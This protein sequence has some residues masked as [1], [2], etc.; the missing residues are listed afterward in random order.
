ME[1]KNGDPTGFE[2]AAKLNF[3]DDY[4]KVHIEAK[5]ENGAFIDLTD[6]SP[7]QLSEGSNV[8]IIAYK[9]DVPKELQKKFVTEL[10]TIL[11]AGTRLI[12]KLQGAQLFFD[13]ILDEDLIFKKDGNKLAV[14]ITGRCRVE[15]CRDD[16]TVNFEPFYAESL[17][18][19]YFQT[20][21]RIKPKALS[22]TTNIYDNFYVVG[23]K[24]LDSYRF[25]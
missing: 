15:P 19:A 9:K 6:L 13:C 22:H 8:R 17:N 20:S 3:Y 12:F 7:V 14:A 1:P 11:A 25:W 2:N 5:Y 16:R 21:L 24:K 18:Q 23:G 10:K 4:A